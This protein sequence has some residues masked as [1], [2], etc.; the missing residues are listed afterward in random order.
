MPHRSK[1]KSNPP[2]RRPRR[3]RRSHE[4]ASAR[5][6]APRAHTCPLTVADSDA[7]RL[8]KT[9]CALSARCPCA[10]WRDGLWARVP[11][12]PWR[13]PSGACRRDDHWAVGPTA[14]AYGR[15]SGL[16]ARHALACGGRPLGRRERVIASGSAGRG[17]C[18]ATTVVGRRACRGWRPVGLTTPSDGR[19]AVRYWVARFLVMFHLIT[20][21]ESVR[22]MLQAPLGLQEMVLAIW[23]IAKGF[24]ASALASV[25]AAAGSGGSS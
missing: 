11:G 17:V 25:A 3:P 24:N 22:I 16:S 1:S 23:L 15:T 21:L 8:A 4:R 19:A 13:I 9:S 5:P 20:P 2:W 6:A 12:L 14:P 7:A 10:V 18:Q